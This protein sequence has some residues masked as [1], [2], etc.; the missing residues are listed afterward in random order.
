MVQYYGTVLYFVF[1][2]I[3]YW[4]N[5]IT[6]FERKAALVTAPVTTVGMPPAARA[7]VPSLETPGTA[8]AAVVAMRG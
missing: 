1:Q 3:R 8:P 7:R 6:S 5:N 4:V 2:G